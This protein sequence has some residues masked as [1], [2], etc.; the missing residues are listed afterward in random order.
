MTGTEQPHT[1]H[2]SSPASVP[3]RLHDLRQELDIPSASVSHQG[4]GDDS[5]PYHAVLGWL[6]QEKKLGRM[7]CLEGCPAHAENP[8]ST[9]PYPWAPGAGP[10]SILSSAS[11][12][13]VGS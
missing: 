4:D 12:V 3:S 2:A 7:T 11:W 10:G 9:G 5:S 13:V 1:E 6:C 8:A